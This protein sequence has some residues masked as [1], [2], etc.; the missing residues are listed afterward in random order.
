M[1][2]ARVRAGCASLNTA[3]CGQSE[4]VAMLYLAG[5]LRRRSSRSDP[6]SVTWASARV[7]SSSSTAAFS[8]FRQTAARPHPTPLQ[9]SLAIER[10]VRFCE[11]AKGG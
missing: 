9:T 4:C 1:E 6:G 5:T 8:C 2:G 3:G 11:V 7:H 10:T